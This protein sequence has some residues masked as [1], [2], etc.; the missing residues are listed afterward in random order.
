MQHSTVPTAAAAQHRAPPAS[1]CGSSSA[2]RRR[3][4]LP[5]ISPGQYIVLPASS[6]TIS[7]STSAARSA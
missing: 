4:A 2:F 6:T 7:T 3:K 5:V 1:A